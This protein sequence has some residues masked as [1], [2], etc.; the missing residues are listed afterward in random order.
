MNTITEKDLYFMQDSLWQMCIADAYN[1]VISVG[2]YDYIKYNEIKSFVYKTPPDYENQFN[3]LAKLAD[4]RVGHSGSSY[5]STMRTVEYIIKN[6]FEKWKIN[7][8]NNHNEDMIK[9]INCIQ[10]NIRKVLSDPNFLMCKRRLRYEFYSD[11]FSNC[12]K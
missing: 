4:V 12:S 1:A 9:S 11:S 6:G 5:G 10:K 8:I 3:K 7:Y 2:L